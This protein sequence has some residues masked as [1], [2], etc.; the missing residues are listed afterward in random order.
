MM[1]IIYKD[2]DQIKYIKNYEENLKMHMEKDHHKAEDVILVPC[3]I[4][5]ENINETK[6]QKKI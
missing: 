6:L 4:C 5:N 1:I 3:Q 2:S